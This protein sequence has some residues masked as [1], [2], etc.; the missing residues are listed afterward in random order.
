M[1]RD[2][3]VVQ[4][5]LFPNPVCVEKELYF[6]ANKNVYYENEHIYMFPNGKL[7]TDTY[8]NLFDAAVWQKYTG[9]QK[10][11]ILFQAGGFGRVQL[12]TGNDA[13]M[14]LDIHETEM[15]EKQI[16]FVCGPDDSWFY[17][18]VESIGKME[19]SD[20]RIL[21][22]E[23]DKELAQVC[24][25]LDICT[26]HRQEAFYH[27][28]HVIR[29]SRFF[30]I[31]DALYGK[32]QVHV[33]D[34]ASEI[35]IPKEKFISVYHNPNTGGSGGFTRGL[36]EIRKTLSK[37]GVTHVVFM[38]DDVAFIP[39]TLYRL[40]M[41][42]SLMKE[43]Y[44][45]EV[46]AGRMFRMDDRKV[47]YTAA[48]IW[49]G[50]EIRHLGLNADMTQL[51]VLSDVNDN[52]H[53]EYGG[54]WFCCFPMGFAKGN[55]PLPFFLHCDDVEYGLR[56]GGTPIILNGIQVWHET[57]EYR[58]NSI[59]EYYD[60]R[61]SRFV[62]AKYGMVE[63]SAEE[64]RQWKDEISKAH[65]DQ[66]FTLEYMR[67]KAFGDYLKGDRW[68]IKHDGRK[69][70]NKL[71]KV[72]GGRIRNAL[73]WR[74]VSMR[75][76]V[77]KNRFFNAIKNVK[78]GKKI[79]DAILKQVGRNTSIY[80]SQHPAIGDAYMAGLYISKEIEN[81]SYIITA[82][83]QGS[84]DVYKGFGLDYI[85][86]LSQE[87]TDCL[88]AYCH[89]MNI[90]TMKIKI[91]HHQAILWRTGIAWKF[92]GINQINFHDLMHQMVFPQIPKQEWKDLT[93]E[94]TTNFNEITRGTSIILFPYSNTLY[95]PPVEFWDCLIAILLKYEYQVYTY[96]HQGEKPLRKTASFYCELNRLVSAVVWAGAFIGTRNGLMDI[97]C[98]APCKKVIFYPTTGGEDWIYGKIID[99]WSVKAFGYARDVL[100]LEWNTEEREDGWSDNI[101]QEISAMFSRED[102]MEQI[103]EKKNT[104]ESYRGN[105]DSGM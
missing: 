85:I 66:N 88:I 27:S 6:R 67:I 104:S 24:L 82:I 5:F 3:M 89:F 64:Y 86:K 14:E 44:M 34:N 53:A 94:E 105:I 10:W 43:E 17:L 103:A 74:I 30:Q 55:D 46:V 28:L 32:L 42:L 92:Q 61:N 39:E 97:V 57:Y 102:H 33:V 31:N 1:E 38:D 35:S 73:S 71:G 2:E 25:A 9:I 22:N 99:Y 78:K 23:T 81:T 49:N 83:S 15:S 90:N 76:W 29:G 48:E 47:Q 18:D 91:L 77:K 80:I 62:N 41:L 51:S 87:E 4:S 19:L 79:L 40:Y 69:L 37:T 7:T 36:D 72:H 58:A 8:M 60:R 84:I 50:G 59:L 26:F 52:T 20:I 12:K 21:A 16:E 75:F 63:T 11:K 70:H 98:G 100:E 54:W 95:T 93:L 13:V 45:D 56:H 101:L 96:V 68:L 65:I